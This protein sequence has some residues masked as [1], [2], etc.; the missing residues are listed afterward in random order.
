MITQTYVYVLLFNLAKEIKRRGVRQMGSDTITAFCGSRNT[1]DRWRTNK[2]IRFRKT[3]H[4]EPKITAIV[5]G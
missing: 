2:K 4:K 1:R 5:N 3:L